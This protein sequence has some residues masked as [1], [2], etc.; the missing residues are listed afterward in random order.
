MLRWFSWSLG[1]E[2]SCSQINHAVILNSPH[3]GSRE[4]GCKLATCNVFVIIIFGLG[5]A[6]CLPTLDLHICSHPSLP[7]QEVEANQH[8][9]P[10]RTQAHSFLRNCLHLLLT[11]TCAGPG[12][13]LHAATGAQPRSKTHGTHSTNRHKPYS[14]GTQT[15]HEHPP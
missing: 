4:V 6:L 7:F 9:D 12:P 13:G 3:L 1:L 5:M 2:P 11:I 8:C 10:G 14:L 15:T